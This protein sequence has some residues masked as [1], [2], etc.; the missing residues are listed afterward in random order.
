MN[1]TS[2]RVERRGINEDGNP[3]VEVEIINPQPMPQE[4]T[5]TVDPDRQ[6][7]CLWTDQGGMRVLPGG[8]VT[9]RVEGTV[10]HW[11]GEHTMEISRAAHTM[12]EEL[13]RRG[14]SL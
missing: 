14:L 3:F 2:I 10:V 12:I 4:Y 1:A 7:L 9:L 11:H 8:K 5:I 6:S 13:R